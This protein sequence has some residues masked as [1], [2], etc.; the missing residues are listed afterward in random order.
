MSASPRR[1]AALALAAVPLGGAALAAAVPLVFLNVAWQPTFSVGAGGTSV[2]VTLSDLAVLAVA[3][4]AFAAGLRDGFGALAAARAVWI[5]SGVFLAWLFAASL[6]P[7]A[8]DPHYATF[9]HLVT[10]AKFTEY[11]LLAPA[12][13]LLLR[14]RADLWW[15]LGAVVAWSVVC[16]GLGVAQYSGARILHAWPAGGRQPSLLGIHEFAAYSAAT[17]ALGLTAVA[18]RLPER[19]VRIAAAVAIASGLVGLVLSGAVAGGIGV[20]L[21]AVALAAVAWRR[22]TLTGS[23]FAVGAVALVL[24]AA[25]LLT[26]R[27]GDITN[28]AHFAGV[29]TSSHS[30]DSRVQTYSQRTLMTYIGYRMWLGRPVLGIGWQAVREPQAYEPYLADAHRRFPDQPALAFPSRAHPW[31]IDDAYLQALAELGALGALAFLA[32]LATAVV[33]GAVVALRARPEAALYGL[34]GLG[35]ALVAAG[36]W[37]GQGLVAGTPYDAVAW[38]GVGF[39]AAGAARARA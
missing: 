30:G 22:R 38:L 10:A 37:T 19:A 8:W 31:G 29:G 26:M 5:A 12:A 20:G 36:I 33:R 23:G 7:R 32:F 2:Q 28:F 15:L 35:W 1:P 16:T 11:A 34:L 3:L 18:W 6:Y 9:T 21:A 24:A 27:S 39:V 4:V 13:V 17:L 14:R 25:G